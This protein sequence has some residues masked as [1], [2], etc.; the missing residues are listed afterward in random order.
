MFT[1]NS[2]SKTINL[3][4]PTQFG[5]YIQRKS[6]VNDVFSAER[7]VEKLSN[8]LREVSQERFSKY[9]GADPACSIRWERQIAHRPWHGDVQKELLPNAKI[10]NATQGFLLGSGYARMNELTAYL[11]SISSPFQSFPNTDIT[12]LV[13]KEF[14]TLKNPD[15][16]Q[17]FLNSLRALDAPLHRAV[18][19]SLIMVALQTPPHELRMIYAANRPTDPKGVHTFM[20]Q[21]R[22]THPA[23]YQFITTFAASLATDGDR[24]PAQNKVLTLFDGWL[25]SDFR[26]VITEDPA[27]VTPYELNRAYPNLPAGPSFS[28]IAAQETQAFFVRAFLDAKIPLQ[29]L[30]DRNSIFHLAIRGTHLPSVA[31][32]IYIRIA[33]QALKEMALRGNPYSKDD[34]HHTSYTLMVNQLTSELVTP[35]LAGAKTVTIG[36]NPWRKNQDDLCKIGN[37]WEIVPRLNFL[38][39]ELYLNPK[40]DDQSTITMTVPSHPSGSF[41]RTP[42]IK[43][44]EIPGM[45]LY[46]MALSSCPFEND[47]PEGLDY[48]TGKFHDISQTVLLDGQKKNS[49]IRAYLHGISQ[50]DSQIR[51]DRKPLSEPKDDISVYSDD[52]GDASDSDLSF[53]IPFVRNLGSE[54]S[55][56]D[57]SSPRS[58]ITESTY[59]SDSDIDDEIPEIANNEVDE[60]TPSESSIDAR[61]AWKILFPNGAPKRLPFEERQKIYSRNP[62]DNFSHDDDVMKSH[63]VLL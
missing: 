19:E 60:D 54:S 21:L 5:E 15:H 39:R 26:R 42:L 22:H 2:S 56:D 35:V 14:I 45:D 49:R 13:I 51:L 25:G 4:N 18:I 3:T 58:T 12:Q 23:Y 44:S 29:E 9:K 55:K 7:A 16:R 36:V 52:S 61:D 20:D 40:L 50:S 38:V 59:V 41:S 53:R 11:N 57:P 33:T 48:I 62:W 17:A 10:T 47:T 30:T 63:S 27:I 1:L 46:K 24:S 32:S 8:V 43:L 37:L 6:M 28:T 31:D 34:T